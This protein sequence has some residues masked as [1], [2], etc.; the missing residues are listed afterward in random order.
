MDKL[1]LLVVFA[2]FHVIPISG[3]D[4]GSSRSITTGIIAWADCNDGKV[5][6]KRLGVEV[7][8]KYSGYSSQGT[9]SLDS[10]PLIVRRVDKSILSNQ[11]ISEDDFTDYTVVTPHYSNPSR[12]NQFSA[13][14]ST[15]DSVESPR[16][17]ITPLLKPLKGATGILFSG[18]VTVG[19]GGDYSTLT[20]VNGLFEKLNSGQVNGNLLVNII[21]DLSETGQNSLNAWTEGSGGPFIVTIHPVGKIKITF[22]VL[23][24]NIKLCL[25]LNGT[26]GLHIDGLNDGT[27]S[28]TMVRLDGYCNSGVIEFCNGASNN[29]VTRTSIYGNNY[30]TNSAV[31]T[32]YNSSSISMNNNT[33]SFCLISSANNSSATDLGVFLTGKASTTN[34]TLI[35]HNIFTNFI[36]NAIFLE[37][38]IFT[39]TIISN[40]DIHNTVA[41][42]T[43]DNFKGINLNSNLG[44]INI[45]NNKIHDI[46]CNTGT[47]TSETESS[48]VIG[49]NCITSRG[50]VLNIY[51]NSISLNGGKT[52]SELVYKGIHIYNQE[53][54]NLNFNSIYIGDSITTNKRSYGI[55]LSGTRT[56]NVLNN[57]ILNARAN[58]SDTA[59]HYGLYI[60]NALNSIKSNKNDIYVIG[61]G[62]FIGHF[63]A[64]RLTFD[65]W[66]NASGQDANSISVDP[67]YN[68]TTSFMPMNAALKIGTPIPGITSD[69]NGTLRDVSSPTLGA[70][71]LPC[72]NPTSGGS[73][74]ADQTVWDNNTPALITNITP[75]SGY[76]GQ[77]EY[78]W[79]KAQSPFV[80]WTDIPNSNTSSYLPDKITETTMFKRLAKSACMS[81]WAGTAETNVVTVTYSINK[82]KGSTSTD[83]NIPDNWTRGLVP[84]SDANIIFDDHPIHDCFLDQDRS[85]NDISINQSDTKLNTNGKV[86]TVKGNLNLTNGAKIDATSTNSCIVFSGKTFQSIPSGAFWGAK[87]YSLGINNASGVSFLS[88]LMIEQLLTICAGCQLIIPVEKLIEVK[89]KIINN[90]GVSGLVIKS[91]PTGTE[92][93]GSLI[94]HNTVNQDPEVPAT[95]EMYTKA[96]LVN[97]SYRWQFFGIPL[98][99]IIANPTFS[100]SYVREMHENSTTVAGH[101]VQLQ[102]ESQ[103]TSFTGYEITQEVPKT[104]RFEG[105]LENRNYN[106]AELSS[107]LEATYKGQHLIAN[108][109]TSAINIKNTEMI[110]NSLT[111]GDGMEKT[112]YL[113]NTGSKT[114]WS[115]NDSNGEGNSNAPGQYLAIPQDQAGSDIPASIPSMQAFLVMVKTPGPTAT[116]SIPYNSTGTIVKNSSLQR[117][118]AAE[119]VF[120][121]IDVIGSCLGD[122]MWLFTEPTCTRGFDNGWDG[123]K[124]LGSSLLPQ[125]Y[126]SQED[127][128][129]QVI[130]SNDINNTYLG[131]KAGIDTIYT[132]TFNQNNIATC[133]QNIYLMDLIENK[134][135]EITA[136][137]SSYTFHSKSGTMEE[138]R[139]KIIASPANPDISDK[140]TDKDIHIL[141]VFNSKNTIIVNN[142][143]SQNGYL[144]L[145]DITGRFI[146]KLQFSANTIST[147]PVLLPIGAYLSKA[148]TQSTKLTTQLILGY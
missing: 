33:I 87:V 109:Y 98:K 100:G 13:Y 96:S 53:T 113:Y 29:I 120:T 14:A 55:Y 93:N 110:A 91:S 82:W 132:M 52:Q 20:G 124:L 70:Y 128:D 148:I 24:P 37:G 35:D 1:Y 65:D 90:A 127:A 45:F 139:F 59:K 134:T 66:K 48:G 137:K 71:E 107:T 58:I 75:A 105:V 102:N 85:V 81:N 57:I 122:Q 25:K 4:P 131:F 32:F 84:V 67:E 23:I 115:N 142:L 17:A 83:W 21:S 92:L 146:L 30:S 54:T 47:L 46:K 103:M 64:D 118:H 3:Q 108:P 140:S 106:S 141:S 136:D 12:K 63:S 77:L 94:F 16:M 50:D 7:A 80:N 15:S 111:F 104:I 101:W 41:I 143:S 147:F 135:V 42:S 86:L 11:S 69:I 78:K 38:G 19:T 22:E 121:R 112:V 36:K 99:S 79:Q 43:G 27:N 76:S 34:G 123:Y 126:A 116:V 8:G 62:S 88:D 6:N 119:K 133:Y 10:M 40:N 39:N 89:G 73:I 74:S 44:T 130:S 49:I 114:D 28:L 5:N 61:K 144:Y 2:I 129:Y 145:Y 26:K 72:I 125:I 68:S 18:T 56:T 51:N 97:G 117:A 95:V 60:H 138:N 31:I 9:R